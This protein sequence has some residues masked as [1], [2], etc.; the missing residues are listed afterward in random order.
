MSL[1]PVF[2]PYWSKKFSAALCAKIIRY[3]LEHGAFSSCNAPR[4]LANYGS[5]NFMLVK[6]RPCAKHRFQPLELRAV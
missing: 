3:A 4:P 5:A 1:T 6:K 2:S